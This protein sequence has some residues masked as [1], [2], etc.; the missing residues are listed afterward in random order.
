MIDFYTYGTFNG[1]RVAIMLEETELEYRVH[2]VDLFAGEQ[3]QA[4]FLALNPSGRIPTIVDNDDGQRL[5]VT[6]SAAILMYLAEKSGM[7][8]PKER[9]AR[10][11]VI[12]WLFF[13]ATDI[14]P[15]L[16]DSFYLTQLCKTKQ[17]EAGKLLDERVFALYQNFDEQLAKH[18]FIGGESYSI[19]DIAVFPA[20]KADDEAFFEKYSNIRRWYSL[21][22][23]RPAVQR[24]MAIPN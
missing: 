16:F 8:L 21:I 5:I 10:A 20:L 14:T 2:K 6:Q 9:V 4:A 18:E 1:R 23:Q 12:E 24:G 19:A 22:S 17:L 11:K 13:H 7:L 15:T 3:R